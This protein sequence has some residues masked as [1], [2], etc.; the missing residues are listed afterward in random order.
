M[1]ANSSPAPRP[2]R[3]SATV[4]PDA[5]ADIRRRY[6][7][8]RSGVRDGTHLTLLHVGADQTW[9]ASGR[10]AEPGA[11]LMLAI[12]SRSTAADHFKHEPPTP[13]EMESAILAVEDEVVR[14]RAIGTD[15]STLI[16]ADVALREIAR[17][18]GA[19][20]TPETIL[21]RDAVEQLFARLAAV[22]LGRPASH[23]GIPTDPAFAAT[24]LVL[25]EFMHHL[26]FEA[27]TLKV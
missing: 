6:A 14:A 19:P 17:L 4:P 9:V 5:G 22:T 21:G 7:A 20:A 25:R 2:Q 11:V 8:I 18:A 10:G 1:P 26:K 16:S 24:L 27:I 12:G 3:T 23:E 13:G 15:G